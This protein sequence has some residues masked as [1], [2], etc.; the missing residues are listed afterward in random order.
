MVRL[1]LVLLYDF[2]GFSRCG[3]IKYFRG[4]EHALRQARIAPLVPE[5]PPAGTVAKRAEALTSQLFRMDTSSFALVAHSMGG[6]DARHLITHLDPDRRVKSLLTVAT[7]HRGT[8][9]ANWLLES[10]GLIPAWIRYMGR[11]SLDELTPEARAAVPIPDRVDV[12]Y[13]SYASCRPLNELPFWLRPFGR[14]VSGDSD[15][16]VPID[17]AQW[18]EFRGVMH[19]DHFE[20]VGWSLALSNSQAKR[21]FDHFRFWTEAASEAMAAA[22]N[23]IS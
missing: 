23:T 19:T 11:P 13:A 14:I 6:L 1:A 5:V 4:V 18:G 12:A 17:S 7:P 8:L 2:L 16:L 15:G 10:R 9:V 21:P 3:P 20:F 22:E